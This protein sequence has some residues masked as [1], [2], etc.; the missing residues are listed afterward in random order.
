M[1]RKTLNTLHSPQAKRETAKH[2]N[3]TEHPSKVSPLVLRHLYQH[4]WYY[5]LKIP[6]FYGLLLGC[7]Y[8]AWYTPHTAVR[9]LMYMGMGYLWMGIVTF[10]HDCTHSV[11]FQAKWKNWVFGLFSTL[12]VLVTFIAF[13][14]DHLE[15]HR[16]NR[17]SRD[18]DAFTMGKRGVL[19]FVVF[20]A[21]ILLGGVLTLLHFTLLYP[22]QKFTRPQWL[23]HLGEIAGRVVVVSGLLAWTARLGVQE[24]F[25]A[26]WLIPAYIFSVLNSM[27]FLAEHY[28]TPWA[29]GQL[30]GTRTILS[31]PLQR[32]FWN[33]IN[34]HIGHHV[35]PA[36]PWYN[37]QKLHAALWLESERQ[38]A[39]VDRSY[40]AVFWQAC[41]RGPE[42]LERNA[43]TNASRAV[44]VAR[45]RGLSQ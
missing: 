22:V 37:L 25:L 39:V 44:R 38:A 13:R 33:N 28:D 45:Q 26:L 34:Y 3:H 21:Y 20:Y 24:Q 11:L 23:L 36:V 32:F 31:N 42:S 10:M 29:S 2:M 16:F 30:L 43:E 12:P 6:L 27:R 15:H 18:P 7:G 40:L 14:S 8:M 35:Y 1:I 19:D 41:L 17:T 5:N 4:T 9:W